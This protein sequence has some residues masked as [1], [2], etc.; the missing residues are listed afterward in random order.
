MVAAVP[1]SVMVSIKSFSLHSRFRYF[2]V[3]QPSTLHNHCWPRIAWASTA[4]RRQRDETQK[5][6][7]FFRQAAQRPWMGA[8]ARRTGPVSAG[9]CARLHG[10]ADGVVCPG[11]NDLSAQRVLKK[12]EHPAAQNAPIFLFT[13]HPNRAAGRLGSAFRQAR[14]PSGTATPPLPRPH[15]RHR[16]DPPV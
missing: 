6:G 12:W 15:S 7:S 16:H 5:R 2:I 8:S 13:F 14:P 10:P 1:S 9:R 3:P 4:K 11:N